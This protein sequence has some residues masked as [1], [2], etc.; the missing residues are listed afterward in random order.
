MEEFGESL[1]IKK[2]NTEPSFVNEIN[3]NKEG[4]ETND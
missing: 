3:C 2:G 4:V 1:S